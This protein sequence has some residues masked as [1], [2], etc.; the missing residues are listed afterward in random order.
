VV[1][2]GRTPAV[3]QAAALAML[4]LAIRTVSTSGAAPFIYSKF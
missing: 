1:N 3:L 4:L 2:F